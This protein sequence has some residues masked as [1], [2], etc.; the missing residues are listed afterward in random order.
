V[1]C[2]PVGRYARLP[3][4]PRISECPG[5]RSHQRTILRIARPEL[6]AAPPARRDAELLCAP[7]GALPSGL[8]QCRVVGWQD[9]GRRQILWRW[10]AED[11][12]DHAGGLFARQGLLH[13][14]RRGERGVDEEPAELD[15]GAVDG[16]G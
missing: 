5:K 6:L 13:L 8:S 11:E 14:F 16:K 4:Q 9:D 7:S 15:D 10:R 2:R 3:L 1:D 12:A